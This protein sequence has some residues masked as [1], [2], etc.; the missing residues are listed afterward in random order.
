M[1]IFETNVY[2]RPNDCFF[3]APVGAHMSAS[4]DS[5]DNDIFGIKQRITRG[6]V[7]IYPFFVILNRFCEEKKNTQSKLLIFFG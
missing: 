6:N 7:H 4:F 1:S 2:V 3:V 5:F